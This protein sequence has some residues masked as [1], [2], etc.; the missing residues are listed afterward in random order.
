MS[1]GPGIA[2]AGKWKNLQPALSEPIMR[3]L[4]ERLGFDQMTPVQAATLPKFLQHKDVAV[5]VRAMSGRRT[6]PFFSHP[7]LPLRI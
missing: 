1:S 5:E 2:A 4:T 6:T 3:V 7:S